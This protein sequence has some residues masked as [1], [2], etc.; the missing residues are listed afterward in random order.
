MAKMALRQEWHLWA[1]ADELPSSMNQYRKILPTAAHGHAVPNA[2]SGCCT[3]L[4]HFT[5]CPEV[6]SHLTETTLSSGVQSHL[7]E[8]ML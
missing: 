7:T 8:T 2:F 3:T 5:L 6:Q 1:S 4:F